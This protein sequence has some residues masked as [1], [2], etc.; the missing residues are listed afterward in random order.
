MKNY[1]F[2]MRWKIIFSQ[3]DRKLSFHNEMKNNL[4]TMRWKQ[5][6]QKPVAAAGWGLGSFL[7]PH[8]EQ[9]FL[10]NIYV[11]HYMIAF[12]RT[13]YHRYLYC[14]LWGNFHSGAG[15]LDDVSYVASLRAND[16]PDSSVGYIE[17]GCLLLSFQNNSF[18][19]L[20]PIFQPFINLSTHE[21]LRCLLGWGSWGLTRASGGPWKGWGAAR[22]GGAIIWVAPRRVGGAKP[23]L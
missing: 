20:V 8:P 1:L 4:F 10:S 19:A 18:M 15:K 22:A 17:V 2:T 12:I 6:W 14:H 21:N 11:L 5:W 9:T 16:R 13:Y 3:W 23:D 7:A